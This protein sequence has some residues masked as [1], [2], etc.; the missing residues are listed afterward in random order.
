MVPD[1]ELLEQIAAESS[2]DSVA[3]PS[4]PSDEALAG[5]TVGERLKRLDSLMLVVPTDS[6]ETLMVEYEELL[7]SALSVRYGEPPTPSYARNRHSSTPRSNARGTND[8]ASTQ[9]DADRVASTSPRS[10]APVAERSSVATESPTPSAAPASTTST[11]ETPLVR[12]NDEASRAATTTT[13]TPE[14]TALAE[15]TR[16]NVDGDR[17]D[18]PLR[19]R[20]NDGYTRSTPRSSLR[21]NNTLS[22]TQPEGSASS[23]TTNRPTR[24]QSS[25]PSRRS[26]AGSVATSETRGVEESGTRVVQPRERRHRTEREVRRNRGDRQSGASSGRRMGRRG[27]AHRG[28]SRVRTEKGSVERRYT[29]GLAKFRA[30]DYRQ[31]IELLRPVAASSSGFRNTARYYLAVSLERTGNVAGA[32]RNFRALKGA[33]GSIGEKSWLAV[34][35]LLAKS[36][37]TARARR[38]LQQ[39]TSARSGSSYVAEADRMLRRMR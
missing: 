8:P 3:A 19:Q 28:S 10:P 31:A 34:A 26:N 13:R 1:V 36:G 6:L 4:S 38:E 37:D 23:S 21:S 32:L 30:G 24:S 25:T 15:G 17:A 22:G 16:T 27:G 39:F 11:P 18:P 33:S 9:S 14:V 12:T 20:S 5:L 29:E 2:T 7:D 35:R